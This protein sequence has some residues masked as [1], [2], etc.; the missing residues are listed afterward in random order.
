M[1]LKKPR[2]FCI[3]LGAAFAVLSLGA[4]CGGSPPDAFDNNADAL[5]A[6]NLPGRIEAERYNAGGEAVGYHDTT[7]GNSGGTLR[8]DGVDIEPTTDTGGGYNVGWT[9]A[10]EWLAYDINVA[11]DGPF[12][13]TARVSSALPGLH[14][15]H[16]EVDGRSVG[17]V[18]TFDGGAGW[19]TFQDVSARTDSLSAGAHRL[20]VV[21][22]TGKL[23]LNHLTF[24]STRG[25]LV[26]GMFD[27]ASV[28]P[29]DEGAKSPNWR[30]ITDRYLVPSK[31]KVRRSFNQPTRFPDTLSQSAAAGDAALGITSFLSVKPPDNDVAGVTRGTYDGRI[32]SLCAS[33]PNGAYLTMQ[34]EPEDNMT[35]AT[36]VPM[37]RHFYATCKA[38][39]SNLKIG[40]VAMA[41]QWRPGS[42]TTADMNAWDVGSGFSDF[43]GVDTYVPSWSPKN[44]LSKEVNF[45]RWY[46]WA[47]TKNKVLVIAEYG[48]EG[49]QTGGMSDVDR[50]AL[51][52]RS[53]K[54]VYESAPRIRMVLYW[55]S[56]PAMGGTEWALTPSVSVGNPT[57]ASTQAW[58][59]AIN[60]Y[61]STGAD[62]FSP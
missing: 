22:D 1:F 19:Q 60:T 9:D 7:A 16:L 48:I 38:A 18:F 58:V 36:F 44:D 21:F 4:G 33:M 28:A 57:S 47:L 6:L 2:R 34:H 37:F 15:L 31:F 45:Q 5:G 13:V 56:A 62:I 3:S 46:Q 26:F 17:A 23:N 12:N 11:S 30:A 50:A 40:Y 52:T 49:Q 29:A 41:Y 35:G 10:G 25:P 24:T 14:R 8:T 61:G 51:F 42:A 43:L 54:W 27:D 20:R 55:N 32:R 39:N 59:N 53:M